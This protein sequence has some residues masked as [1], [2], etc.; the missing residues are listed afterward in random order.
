MIFN[1][2]SIYVYYIL[3]Q[4]LCL[5]MQID[6][7]IAQPVFP[8]LPPLALVHVVWVH[9]NIFRPFDAF[10]PHIPFLPAVPPKRAD[11][12][13]RVFKFH[14]LLCLFWCF[15]PSLR[16]KRYFFVLGV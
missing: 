3:V 1:F 10:A 9:G 14:E 6:I 4:S 16:D 2:I 12:V 15:F 13:Q 11:P 8:V 5:L 7:S